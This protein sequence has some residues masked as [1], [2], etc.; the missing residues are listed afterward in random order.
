M[1]KCRKILSMFGVLGAAVLACS[2][3][4]VTPTPQ[5]GAG[6]SLTVQ[7]L[8]QAAGGLQPPPDQSEHTPASTSAPTVTLTATLSVPMISV[9][10]ANNCRTGPGA[11]YDYLTALLEGEKAEVVGKYTSVSPPYWVIKK[12]SVTCWLWGQNAIVE[13]NTSP[14]PEMI[15]PPSPTPPPTSTLTTTPVP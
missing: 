2:F 13:G 4:T 3:P 8:T 9:S 6:D 7:A 15:P 10:L 11:A 12:G 1:R 14:L 5:A